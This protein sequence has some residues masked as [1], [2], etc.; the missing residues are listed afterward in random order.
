MVGFHALV[1]QF[2]KK[3]EASFERLYPSFSQRIRVS[4]AL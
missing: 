3:I 1:R 2:A 4:A